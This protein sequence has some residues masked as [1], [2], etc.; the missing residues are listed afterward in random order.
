MMRCTCIKFSVSGLNRNLHDPSVILT[1][2][3]KRLPFIVPT[4]VHSIKAAEPCEYERDC[5]L[6]YDCELVGG[7]LQVTDI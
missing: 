7:L 2:I 6:V 3:M 1:L 4:T 5:T